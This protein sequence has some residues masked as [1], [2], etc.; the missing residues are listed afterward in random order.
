MSLLSLKEACARTLQRLQASPDLELALLDEASELRSRLREEFTGIG[1]LSLLL[2]NQ[3][4]TEI[5]IPACEEI[6][7]EESGSFHPVGDGFLS[8]VTFENFRQRL[9]READLAPNLNTPFADGDWRH[10]RVHMA[11]APIASQTQITIRTRPPKPWTLQRLQDHGWA[12]ESAIHALRLW[13]KEKQNLLVIGPTGSGKTSVLNALLQELDPH[14]R[15][16]CMEDTCE[17]SPLKGVSCKLLTRYD[18][19]GI[20]REYQLTDLLKQSLR[21]RPSRLVLGE[22]RGPEAKDL[23]MALATG[24]RGSLGTLHAADARQ[25]LLRLEMLVQLGAGQWDR[26]A[27]RQLIQLSVD[28]IVVTGINE[29]Q[30]RLVGIYRIASLETFGFLMEAVWQS[31]P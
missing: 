26:D 28:G 24:H 17:L 8:P 19:N 12:D 9:A 23:L 18:A 5:L 15:V 4:I 21:M 31:K 7:V 20:L 6:W 13:L 14:E 27:I 3:H 30:R 11:Q 1:P 22:V 10:C 25:A 2:E 29:G 16:I